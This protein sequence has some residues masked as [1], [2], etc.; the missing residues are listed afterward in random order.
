MAPDSTTPAPD[1][2]KPGIGR[3]IRKA[4]SRLSTAYG[5]DRHA[6]NRRINRISRLKPGS[7]YQAFAEKQLAYLE[8]ALDASVK[9]RA[10]RQQ[11]CPK[12]VYPE[13]G[14]PILE[15]KNEIISAIKKNR[16]LII[17]GETGS[18]KTTQIPKFCLDAGRGIDGTIGCTQPRRIAATTV[19]RRIAEELGESLG[20]S[21]GYKIRF[22]DK[23][24]PNGFIKIMTDG[25]LLAEIQADHFLNQYDTLIVDEAHERSLNID[26]TLGI[27]KR[28]LSRRRDLKLIVTSATIDTEKFS[29]A[30]DDAPIIEVSGRMYP[31]QVRY[32]VPSLSTGGSDATPVDM[33]VDA[34]AKIERQSRD[35]D[36]LVFM[37]TEQDIRES[38]RLLEGRCDRHTVVFPLF[39]RLAGPEQSRVFASVAGRK[40]IVATNL[41]ETSITIPGIKYVVDTGLARIPRYTPRSRCT[42][43][44]IDPVSRSSA[45]QRKGRCGR[46]A[47]GVCIRLYSEE[48]YLSR[49]LYTPPEILRSNLADVI[50]RMIALG[51]GEVADFPFIDPPP[52]KMI[53]DGYQ[54]L[55]A[56]NAI[57][58]SPPIRKK[59]NARHRYRLTAD[60]KMMAR[61]PIDPRLSRMLI[62]ARRRV[63][64]AEIVIIASALSIQ[65][66]RE[67]PLELQKEADRVHADWVDP[68]SDFI[69]LLNIWRWFEAELSTGKGTRKMKRSCREHFLSYRRMREWRD[70]HLQL[71]IVL[72]ESGITVDPLSDTDTV[73]VGK[74][75]EF[76]PRYAA[77]HQ[78]I[79]SGFLSNIACRKE[80]NIYTAA[81]GREVMI[82][83]GSG[84]FNRAGKWIV[85]A[86]MVLTSQ[87]FARIV[88]NIDVDWLEPLAGDQCKSTYSHPHWDRKKETVMG[89]EQVSLFGLVIVPG[90]PVV[91]GRIDAEKACDVFVESALVDGDLLTLP[92]FVTHNQC[93]VEAVLNLENRLRRRD[94]FV[95]HQVL[96][97][98][99][100]QRLSGIWNI[101]L[102]QREIQKAGGDRFLRVKPEDLIRY[103]PGDDVLSDFP[104]IIRLGGGTYPC[105]Y[106]YEPGGREDGITVRIP[107]GAAASIPVGALDWLVPGLIREK[108]QTL[109]RGLPKIYRRQLG[110]IPQ[111]MEK[112]E[113]EIRGLETAEPLVNL[114][115]RF[116]YQRFG[117]HIPANAWPVG[118]LPDY[119]KMRVTVTDTDGR[120]IQSSRDP[121]I[122]RGA[123]R[124][125]GDLK[126]FTRQGGKWERSGITRWDF[127]DLPDTVKL[128]ATDGSVLV[129]YPSLVA[130]ADS[131]TQVKM[132][133]FSDWG[134][135]V[136]AHLAGVRKLATLHLVKEMKFLRKSLK[137]SE[138][139]APKTA[140]FGGMSEVT[141]QLFEKVTTMLFEKNIRTKEEFIAC[142]SAATP[143]LHPTGQTLISAV[144][145][146]FSA[147][148]ATR[149]QL[150]KL[151]TRYMARSS[152]YPFIGRRQND[153]DRLVPKNFISLYDPDRLDRLPL[154]IQAI[155]IRTQRAVVD[156]EKDHRKAETI[157]PFSEHLEAMLA[158]LSPETSVRKRQAVEAYF[159]LL[160]AFKVSVF[161]QELKA[162]Q[163]VSAKRLKEKMAEIERM[164]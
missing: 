69:T 15:K 81:K 22:R 131:P 105:T 38:C 124:P 137:I 35:G 118:S 48:D 40:I 1:I 24:T 83:P 115:G 89:V 58:S 28:L 65:D 68:A 7:G 146:I 88:A 148:H 32:E 90:R 86:E 9:R 36:I 25:I 163:P 96:V 132:R 136:T 63:C 11:H 30:F 94:L 52:P 72:K 122:L 141:R 84:L 144:E 61:L 6:L 133:L 151:A 102:L 113:K 57:M 62:E 19:A 135:A 55:L 67:R 164:S 33:A 39:A 134:Q 78:S 129:T 73:A 138:T 56:L 111:V 49:P 97:D 116:F 95:G 42:L 16:V 104:E 145:P 140:A 76:S 112:V 143:R 108:I 20:G 127:G 75:G 79:L 139:T 31:V 99:Y 44:P 130:E 29:R 85:A 64:V 4:R 21:V 126:K 45:D 54:L 50:L 13:T 114:L 117:V 5:A 119:L 106:S 12:A 18:G 77:V 70:V 98:F 34:V 128:S 123:S 41:A 80:K 8:Q 155:L 14:L 87:L 156:L 3:R 150:S 43:L 159:W 100:R 53:Q 10:W 110:P 82:F 92:G 51:L 120:E 27:V 93:Q 147:C 158:T 2:A 149:T 121:A 109:I 162:P 160:E 101:R 46:V 17:S 60:G 153:L 23:T 71:C 37:P 47:D 26:L 161:A 125:A 59:R 142:L 152:I 154:Y 74:N 66:P 157:R 91:Y 103:Q 107:A